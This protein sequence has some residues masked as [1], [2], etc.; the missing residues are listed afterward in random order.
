MS[1]SGL[2]WDQIQPETKGSL[3][4]EGEPHVKLKRNLSLALDVHQQA[5]KGELPPELPAGEK[6]LAVE[7]AS[8]TVKAALATDR[9]ALKARSEKLMEQV[10]LRL[11]FYKKLFGK[12]MTDADVKALRTAPRAD[13]EAALGPQ[14]AKYDNLNWE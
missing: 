5:M 12:E 14:M 10:F 1:D 4:F 9:T 6:R 11:L 7:S 13:L 8:A 3:T 2:P